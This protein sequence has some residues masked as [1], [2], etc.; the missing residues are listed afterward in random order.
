MKAANREMD[1]MA[2]RRMINKQPLEGSGWSKERVAKALKCQAL[3]TKKTST[4]QDVREEGK[5]A[6]YIKVR[7]VGMDLKVR[8][9]K[10]PNDV[11]VGVPGHAVTRLLVASTDLRTHSVSTGDFWTAFLQGKHYKDGKTRDVTFWCPVMMCVCVA[12]LTGPIYGEQI[13][14][15]N[16]KDTIG[17]DYLVGE[18]GFEESM[19]QE[20][21]YY[22][23]ERDITVVLW[24]D[25]PF[26]KC[27]LRG[28]N[29]EAWE[30]E[31]IHAQM[32][33]KFKM[34]NFQRLSHKK[35]LTY[36]GMRVSAAGDGSGRM[37]LDS[38]EYIQQIL[39]EENMIDCNAVKVP[40][41]RDV[42][43]A[44]AASP[45]MTSVTEHTHNRAL[46]GKFQWLNTTCCPLI[47]VP[48]SISK[49]YDAKPRE[50]CKV[51]A[52]Q[53][54]RFLKGIQYKALSSHPDNDLGLVLEVDSDYAGE[55]ALTGST[56]S[57]TAYKLTFKGMLVAWGSKKQIDVADSSG[58]AE[59]NAL[60]T[61]IKVG[62]HIQWVAEELGIIPQGSRLR[63]YC[64]SNA[65]LGFAEN[66]GNTT[67]MKHID[68]R[69]DWVR[70]VRDRSQT[71]L[72]R[73]DT[74][75][76]GADFFSKIMGRA[77]FERTGKGLVV[78]LPDEMR[79]TL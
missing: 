67:K 51:M 69:S 70:D 13:G 29:G 30:M 1:E 63:V 16:W 6:Y 17:A 35:P 26:I 56:H 64:D 12:E 59:L 23:K 24:V 49:Q 46:N 3:F 37:Y 19:N 62:M 25:D 21:S 47:A 60:A 36:I 72:Y 44:A 40:M 77:E 28:K 7:L 10:H 38:A 43:K 15:K 14:G 65:A 53:M 42:L 50:G 31:R 55:Y 78:E 32:G 74:K 41:S 11:Y 20:G 27:P 57:R 9:R 4:E 79:Y 76:N 58:R 52:Q 8:S 5:E 66:N 68:I 61:G 75:D 45:L 34:R 2:A 18:L 22:H 54:L 48:T 33:S 73:V 71:D 39:E